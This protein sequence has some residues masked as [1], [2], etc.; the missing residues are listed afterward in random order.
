MRQMRKLQTEREAG[1]ESARPGA[2]EQRLWRNEIMATHLEACFQDDGQVTKVKRLLACAPKKGGAKSL[3]CNVPTNV[4]LGVSD[5]FKTAPFCHSS[6]TVEGGRCVSG[7][8]SNQK[9]TEKACRGHPELP[10]RHQI[11]LD[12]YLCRRFETALQQQTCHL[13]KRYIHT[14]II[15]RH[16]QPACFGY[17]TGDANQLIL[18]RSA[19]A[20]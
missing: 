11:S 12:F 9:N 3:K 13:L 7:H 5:L 15:G 20:D 18:A 1:G 6:C 16:Q 8:H 2:T 17:S 10:E 19:A 4:E 14:Y